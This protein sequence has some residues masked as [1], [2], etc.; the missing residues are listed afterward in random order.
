MG[1]DRAERLGDGGAVVGGGAAEIPF[2]GAGIDDQDSDKVVREVGRDFP[3]HD[4]F[5]KAVISSGLM[6]IP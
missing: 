4:L 1:D 2:S 5:A 6:A 3:P